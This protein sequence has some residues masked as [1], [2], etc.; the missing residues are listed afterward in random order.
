MAIW[1][2]RQVP[3]IG[4]KVRSEAGNAIQ[5]RITP[6]NHEIKSLGSS[7]KFFSMEEQCDSLLKAKESCD[8][9]NLRWELEFQTRFLGVALQ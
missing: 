8:Q 3:Q 7:P 9:E 6:A 1:E 2:T 4:V 5:D